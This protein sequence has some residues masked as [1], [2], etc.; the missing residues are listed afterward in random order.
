[1]ERNETFAKVIRKKPLLLFSVFS[2]IQGDNLIDIVQDISNRISTI[3]RKKG[4]VAK[5]FNKT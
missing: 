5:G 4:T 2:Q 3:L 1:M